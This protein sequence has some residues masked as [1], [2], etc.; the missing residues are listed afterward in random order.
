MLEPLLAVA[1]APAVFSA[2]WIASVTIACGRPALGLGLGRGAERRA[3]RAD[4][5]GGRTV[6]YC[7][8]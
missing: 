2:N 6:T 5:A 3:A 8:Y 1:W 4:G 7:W